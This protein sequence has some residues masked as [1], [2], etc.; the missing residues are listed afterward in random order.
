MRWITAVMLIALTAI[1]APYEVGQTLPEQVFEDQFGKKLQIDDSTEILLFAFEMDPGKRAIALLKKRPP[2]Y[3]EDHHILFI[4]DVS[5]APSFVLSFFMLP[6]FE[7]YPFRMGLIKDET[8]HE[9][10]PA[11][12]ET[13]TLIR[14]DK[15]KIT[16]IEYP[17]SDAE[18]LKAL[19]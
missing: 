16:A 5:G 11:K 10:Y 12:P 8:F 4:N 2:L 19:P 6:K 17:G 9:Q 13:L 14:L 3:L 18:I 1:A 7:D 15:R